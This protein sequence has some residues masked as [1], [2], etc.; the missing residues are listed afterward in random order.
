MHGGRRRGCRDPSRAHLNG[1]ERLREAVLFAE[2]QNDLDHTAGSGGGANGGGSL[3]SLPHKRTTPASAPPGTL[4]LSGVSCAWQGLPYAHYQCETHSV[5][6]IS[7]AMVPRLP[8]HG[9]CSARWQQRASADTRDAAAAVG[10]N[11][12]VVACRAFDLIVVVFAA[13]EEWRGPG[14]PLRAQR[15]DHCGAGA[16]QQ[17]GHTYGELRIMHRHLIQSYSLRR[18]HVGVTSS[19]PGGP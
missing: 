16:L 15:L 8:Q 2:L 7:R 14:S 19:H 10:L 5:A 12:T 3:A 1:I 6:S 17:H 13:R 4:L 9:E 11:P 18:G